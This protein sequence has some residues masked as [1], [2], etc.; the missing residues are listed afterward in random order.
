VEKTVIR[1]SADVLGPVVFPLSCN[2]I[3]GLRVRHDFCPLSKSMTW[4]GCHRGREVP[5]ETLM[6]G[7]ATAWSGA[8]PGGLRGGRSA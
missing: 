3:A 7:P 4:G 1:I 6:R 8:M 5:S 2:G